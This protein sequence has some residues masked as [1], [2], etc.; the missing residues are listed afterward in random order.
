M[1]LIVYVI[2]GNTYMSLRVVCTSYEG[3]YE[4]YVIN[5]GV[6]VCYEG[7]C[8]LYRSLRSITTYQCGV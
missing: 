4:S 5:E 8:V 1:S 3:V 6:C 7:A 2:K